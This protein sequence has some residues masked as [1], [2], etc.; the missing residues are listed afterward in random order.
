MT[1]HREHLRSRLDDPGHAATNARPEAPGYTLIE[2]LVVIAVVS[3]LMA[4]LLPV[5]GKAR[6][7]TK[8]TVCRSNLRQVA[9]G[10]LTYLES[11]DGTFYSGLNHSFDYGGWQGNGWARRRPVNA[12]LM[13]PIDANENDARVFKCPSRVG[14]RHY[15]SR[16]NSYK[17]NPLLADWTRLPKGTGDS[18]TEIMSRISSHYGESLKLSQVYQPAR[19]LW[20]GDFE[21]FDRS[22]PSV[23]WCP[24]SGHGRPHYYNLAFVDGHVDYVHVLRTMFLTKTYRLMPFDE[25]EFTRKRQKEGLCQCGLP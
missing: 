18:W 17:A 5:L 21:W 6:E 4:V 3:L 24:V 19:H 2:V 20:I 25:D 15:A 11:N 13:L 1:W 23:R 10:Y 12:G 22:D 16:G 7:L 8:R 9:V 14:A